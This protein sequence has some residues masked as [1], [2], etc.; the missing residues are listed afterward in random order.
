MNRTAALFAALS[1][2]VAGVAVPAAGSVPLPA[3]QQADASNES[4][5]PAAP[6]ARLAGVVAVQGAEVQGDL[7][8]REF[9]LRIARANSS[10]SKAA[11]VAD[12]VADLEQRLEAIEARKQA[13]EEARENG[14][15]SRARYNAEVA[16]VSARG[17][18]VDQRL[19]RTA[20]VSATLPADVLAAN[21]VNAS[22]IDALRTRAESLTGPEVA[23]IAR[24]I[25]GPGAGR[26]LAT[27]GN[28]SVGPPADRPSPE[29]GPSTGPPDT[30]D[31]PDT[32]GTDGPDTPDTN[33]TTDAPDT[34]V[35]VDA[36]V[37]D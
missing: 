34:N 17:T 32:D 20:A 7:A 19:N 4:A 12:Q 18:A 21:D 15:I 33:E 11:V 14:T 30:P 31:V 29:G 3:A 9:G 1:L 37:G 35:T 22:A 36:P 25:A 6:G 13:L 27:A 5:E 16:A 28:D 23:E 10:G 26:G 8:G 24:S 2:V